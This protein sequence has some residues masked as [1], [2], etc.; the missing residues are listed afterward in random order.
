[1]FD[2]LPFPALVVDRETT[3]IRSINER[4]SRLLAPGG[5][6]P[7]LLV[8]AALADLITASLD[9]LV[10]DLRIAA[11]G[12]DLP[13]VP[14]GAVGGPPESR[15]ICQVAAV[16]AERPPDGRARHWLVTC[17]GA[18]G[19]FHQFQAL[20][21]RLQRASDE[22]ADERDRRRRLSSDYQTLEQFA[23][24]MAHDLKGPLR[25]IGSL[26][27]V[28]EH[29]LGSAV[30]P[31]LH[32]LLE[33]VQASAERGRDL[34]DALLEH[35]GAVSGELDVRSLDLDLVVGETI[36]ALAW[37][38]DG[39]EHRLTVASPLG[40]VWADGPLVQLLVENLVG[41]AVKYRSPDRPLEIDIDAGSPGDQTILEIRDNGIGFDSADVDK[42]FQPFRRLTGNVEGHGIG[43]ATCRMICER[44]GWTIEADGWPDAGAR[45]RVAAC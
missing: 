18:G 32:R 22:A 20:N 5:P 29:E 33:R 12:A 10:D 2:Q 45:F 28:I 35:A 8:G 4:A 9:D 26:L 17:R 13:L 24:A 41:N 37:T 36:D 16:W 19:R 38:L 44:H 30:P 6:P 42:I 43:L 15:M 23:H 1:V 14:I 40:T 21:A 27:P 31:D 25:H 11:S 3:R 34:V 39:V 7:G